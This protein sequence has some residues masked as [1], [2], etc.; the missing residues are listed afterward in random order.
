MYSRFSSNSEADA[1]ELFENLEYMNS[2]IDDF[3]TITRPEGVIL[4][5]I[6]PFVYD[7]FFE[8]FLKFGSIRC[9]MF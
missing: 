1:S 3:L 7:H 5:I 4:K 2:R 8:I 6:L 9:R